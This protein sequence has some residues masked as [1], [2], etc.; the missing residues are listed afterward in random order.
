MIIC[1][2]ENPD[3]TDS[4]RKDVDVELRILI[5]G[6]TGDEADVFGEAINEFA[7]R[8]GRRANM[9]AFRID[10]EWMAS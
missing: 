8:M 4:A 1:V 10:K 5:K 9:S 3:L 6:L 7:I 2:L